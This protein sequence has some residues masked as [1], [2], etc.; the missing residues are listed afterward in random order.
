MHLLLIPAIVTIVCFAIGLAVFA[1]VP[2]LKTRAP[3]R[4]FAGIHRPAFWTRGSLVRDL[5]LAFAV[6][7]LIELVI[8]GTDGIARM[9]SLRVLA[10]VAAV[11]LPILVAWEWL[12]ENAN[13]ALRGRMGFVPL[14]AAALALWAVVM[15]PSSSSPD[16]RSTLR[17]L[18]ICLPLCA[19]SV[20]PPAASQA[21][22][23]SAAPSLRTS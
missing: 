13:P 14:L 18:A 2:S 17:R 11:I 4:P 15:G 8:V 22:C 1:V 7:F 9:M 20:A 16:G 6:L 21:A 10:V 19:W 23:A 12:H 5:T 3:W